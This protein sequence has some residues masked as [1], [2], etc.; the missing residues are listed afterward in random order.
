MG[1]FFMYIFSAKLQDFRPYKD[2]NNYI[3]FINS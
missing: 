3:V 1:D 2:E